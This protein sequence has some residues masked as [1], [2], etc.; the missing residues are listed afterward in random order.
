MHRSGLR[1]SH[2]SALMRYCSAVVA[3]G[4]W[5]ASTWACNTQRR[6]DSAPTPTFGP[7]AWQAA[8]TDRC[9]VNLYLYVDNAA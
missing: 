8:Y 2:S 4:R 3:S 5:A 6:S 1:T 9:L 7:I